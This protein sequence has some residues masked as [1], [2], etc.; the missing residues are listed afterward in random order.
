M[1]K[2][3]GL[4]GSNLE[5]LELVV[6]LESV[7]SNLSTFCVLVVTGG[8]L[9]RIETATGVTPRRPPVAMFGTGRCALCSRASNRTDSMQTL[10]CCAATT[11]ATGSPRFRCGTRLLRPAATLLCPLHSSLTHSD[12]GSTFFFWNQGV[13]PTRLTNPRTCGGGGGLA[14]ALPLAVAPVEEAQGAAQQRRCPVKYKP[15]RGARLRG[16]LRPRA[17][18]RPGGYPHHPQGGG[19]RCNR[20]GRGGKP[21]A[22]T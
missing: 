18:T 17:P 3:L 7:G 10:I 15:P 9:E 14:R 12:P 11:T 1:F 4:V 13:A 22:V 21:G 6:C 5:K 16:E 2:R 8:G 20:D 19:P